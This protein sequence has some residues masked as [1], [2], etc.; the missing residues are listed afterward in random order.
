MPSWRLHDINSV[1]LLIYN[2]FVN[3][4]IG[5]C[6]SL[7]LFGK[8][9]VYSDTT[10]DCISTTQITINLGNNI[11]VPITFCLRNIKYY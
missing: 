5:N 10:Y 4:L 9:C 1:K 3:Q 8:N 11:N 7:Y 2:K 6:L